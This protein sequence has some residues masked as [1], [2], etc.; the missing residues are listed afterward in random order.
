MTK[1]YFA[2]L[3]IMGLI[4]SLW[5]AKKVPP[6]PGIPISKTPHPKRVLIPL[7]NYGF[8][9]TEAGV[10]WSFLHL[11]G[12]HVVFATPTGKVAHADERMVTGKDLSFMKSGLMA[13]E[14]AIRTYHE[15]EIAESFLHP[16]AYDKIRSREYDAIFLPGGHDKGM[17]EYLDS[18]V[19]QSTIVEFFEAN[20]QV[21]AICHGTLVVARSV[22]PKTGHSVLWDRQTTG[23]TRYQELVAYY[24]TYFILG[25]YYRTYPEKDQ[26]GITVTMEDEVVSY[27]QNSSQFHR[28]PGFPIPTGRDNS[29]DLSDGYF[30][31]DG[32]YLSARWPGDVYFFS[33]ELL[34]LL[35]EKSSN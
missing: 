12:H 23:L 17:R 31:R 32:N 5:W 33:Y 19:I 10:P 28:G 26:E 20:K 4:V 15:L 6:I 30:Y 18:K 11:A 29:A 21:A 3:F 35:D 25:D 27:L 13:Q 7:P 16:I 22:S 2:L 8:D 14:E 1:L 34:N 9:P 24:M